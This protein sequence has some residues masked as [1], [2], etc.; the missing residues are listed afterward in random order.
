MISIIRASMTP[1]SLVMVL[2]IGHGNSIIPQSIEENHPNP[3]PIPIPI[4]FFTVTKSPQPGTRHAESDSNHNNKDYLG[5][6]LP[7]IRV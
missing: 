6:S 5:L 4:P 3:I 7:R 2:M 1:K